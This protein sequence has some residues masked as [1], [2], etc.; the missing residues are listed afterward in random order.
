M[1]ETKRDRDKE[2]VGATVQKLTTKFYDV[3]KI[4]NFV[5]RGL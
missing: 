4:Y 1:N 3:H 2:R 5:A